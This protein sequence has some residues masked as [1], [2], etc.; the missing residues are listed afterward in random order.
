MIDRKAGD[1]SDEERA[2][3]LDDTDIELNLGFGG[4]VRW[5]VEA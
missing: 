1:E 5:P 2:P 3:L 4:G